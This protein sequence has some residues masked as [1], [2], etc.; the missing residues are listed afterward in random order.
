MY[1]K[2]LLKIEC[3]SMCIIE[4]GAKSSN[5]PYSVAKT[6]FKLRFYRLFD[7]RTF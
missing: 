4:N 6:S 3:E 7:P 2:F 5:T 1:I